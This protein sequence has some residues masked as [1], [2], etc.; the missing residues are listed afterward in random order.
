LKK[1]P[2]HSKQDTVVALERRHFPRYSITASAEATDVKSQTRI[3]ARISDLGRWGCYVDTLSPFVV[4]T[5]VKIGIEKD[6]ARFF[7]EARVL[8]STVGMGMGLIFAVV[9]PAEVSILEKWSESASLTEICR[10]SILAGIYLL[11][12]C[13]D[14]SVRAWKCCWVCWRLNLCLAT[15]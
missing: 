11:D 7:A 13:Q 14:V 15:T 2:D 12:I 9:E 1:M 3:K 4:D 5:V 8:Y 6:K 10:H